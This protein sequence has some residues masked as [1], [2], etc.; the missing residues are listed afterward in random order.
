METVEGGDLKQT[1]VACTDTAFSCSRV[2]QA[3]P[4]KHHV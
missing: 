4:S 1:I 2:L 3:N